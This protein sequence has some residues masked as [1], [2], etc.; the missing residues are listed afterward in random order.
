MVSIAIGLILLSGLVTLLVNTSTSHTE[1][2]KTSAQIENGRYAMQILHDDIQLAGYYADYAPTTYAGATKPCAAEVAGAGVALPMPIGYDLTA[3]A[4]DLAC[5]TN[6]QPNT[7]VLVLRRVLTTT[8]T[9]IVA[10][11]TY[12]QVSQCTNDAT[13][14][15]FLFLVAP[16]TTGSAF[17]LRTKYCDTTLTPPSPLPAQLTPP[18]PL[19]APIAAI[20][21]FVTHIYYISSCNVCTPTADGV[22][23]LKM[24]EYVD[25]AAQTPTPL[26]EGIENMQFDYGVDAD[27]DGSPDSYVSASNAATAG[28]QNVMAVRVYLLARNVSP[29]A[30]YNDSD[31][32][33]DGNA[34]DARTYNLGTAGTVGPFSATG[35]KEYKRHLYTTLVRLENPS[36]RRESP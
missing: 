33:G 28:W 9:T 20:H 15:P 6:L 14:T 7:G 31:P 24:V 3:T 26:V 19:A 8:A 36:S 18:P 4:T 34:S 25:G 2:Q 11:S 27:G 29:T 10:N 21:K 17:T 35:L 32:N 12:L 23:T 5:L 30:N 13:T 22:P 1:M 16:D